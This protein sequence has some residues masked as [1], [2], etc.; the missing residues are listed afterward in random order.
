MASEGILC[1]LPEVTSLL[2]VPPSRASSVIDSRPL[3][4]IRGSRLRGRLAPLPDID[5]LS[6]ERLAPLQKK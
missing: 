3:I 6:Q 4:N 5:H 2:L 1:H